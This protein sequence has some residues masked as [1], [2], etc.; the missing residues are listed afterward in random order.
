MYAYSIYMF[1]DDKRQTI[2]NVSNVSIFNYNT[3]S[4]IRSNLLTVRVLDEGYSRN[5]S[6]SLYCISTLSSTA[7]DHLKQMQCVA[8]NTRNLHI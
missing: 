8:N 3:C 4:H 1:R 7:F 6:C 2:V 5:V